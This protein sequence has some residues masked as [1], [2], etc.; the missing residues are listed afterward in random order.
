MLNI[1]LYELVLRVFAAFVALALHE[2]VKARCSTLLG[3]P[4]PKKSGLMSG[5][6]LKY[7]EP[8][9]FII[10]VFYGFGWGR[11]TP[12]SPLYYKDRKKG[13]FITY[14]TP[15]LINISVGL[16]V[17]L[18][19]GIIN[20][21]SIQ[22]MVGNHPVMVSVTLWIFQFFAHF[23][24]FSIGIALFNMIPIPPL[25]AAKLLQVSVSPNTAVKMSQNEKLLQ[26]LL[27]LLVLFGFVNGIIDPIT[28]MLVSAAWHW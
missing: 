24:R 26:L 16:L 21:V 12:T 9:G 15:S 14:L 6:P 19:V 13:I 18:F 7:L 2:M 28:E 23:A 17:A 5:N 4:T 27:M 3:D 11:P 20:V 1:N 8:I 10:T 25:D 22:E